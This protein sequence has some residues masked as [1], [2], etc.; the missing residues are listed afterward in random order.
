[1]LDGFRL[2]HLGCGAALLFTSLLVAP[3]AARTTYNVSTVAELQAALAAV[4]AGPGGDL[5]ALAPGLHPITTSLQLWSDVTIVGDPSGSAVIDGGGV[6]HATLTPQSANARY[7]IVPGN[8]PFGGECGKDSS[9]AD[10]PQGANAF[11]DPQVAVLCPRRVN[12]PRAAAVSSTSAPRSAGGEVDVDNQL[13]TVLI[14]AV[15]LGFVAVAVGLAVWWHRSRAEQRLREMEIRHRVLERFT[16]SEAFVEFARSEEGKRLLLAHPE[17]GRS[18]RRG[19]AGLLYV[20]LLVLALGIGARIASAGLPDGK[21]DWE[22]LQ[23]QNLATWG[24]LCVCA[25]IALTG[26][27]A[28]SRWLDRR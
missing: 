4:N 12:V 18:A 14:T 15:T 9:G 5:I 20:G 13:Y 19:W 28:L 21:Q 6:T 3:A 26:S 23:K 17:N 16:N 8:A 11:A 2:R 10:I 22:R 1:M 24:T 25:G 7:P 27:G